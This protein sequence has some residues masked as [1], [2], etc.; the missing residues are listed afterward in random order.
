MM[1]N[2]DDGNDDDADG[3][4]DNRGGDCDDGDCAADD[5]NDNKAYLFSLEPYFNLLRHHNYTY[6]YLKQKTHLNQ[7]NAQSVMFNHSANDLSK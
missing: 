6:L 7:M 2:D 5:D 4:D 3:G 1:I